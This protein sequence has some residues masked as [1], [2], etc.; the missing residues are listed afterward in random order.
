MTFRAGPAA[1]KTGATSAAGPASNQPLRPAAGNTPS[2]RA[3][4]S[5]PRALSLFALCF[6]CASAYHTV[7]CGVNDPQ[8]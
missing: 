8:K 4:G 7:H 5:I 3:V 2:R 1:L 6:H